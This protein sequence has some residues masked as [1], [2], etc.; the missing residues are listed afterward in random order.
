MASECIKQNFYF[1]PNNIIPS[2]DTPTLLNI[3][4]K[5]CCFELKVFGNTL[6]SDFLQNDKNGFLFWF[7]KDLIS[8]IDLSLEKLVNDNWLTVTGLSNNSYGTFYPWLFFVNDS[9]EGFIGYQIEWRNVLINFDEGAYRVKCSVTTVLGSSFSTTSLEYC[10]EKY[11]AFR[12]EGTVRIEYNISGVSGDK[13]NDKIKKDFG[14][15]FWY[16]SI[17][18]KGYFGFPEDTYEQDYVLYNNGQRAYVTD[19]QEPE[20]ILHLKHMPAYVH[21]IMSVDVLRADQILISDY[22]ARNAQRWVQKAVQ[23]PNEYKPV[24]KH[25]K[26]KQAPVTIRLRQEYNNLKKTRQ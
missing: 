2:Q 21:D 5:E 13:N 6:T 17:R 18:L 4:D 24:W 10:L 16:N 3:K 8:T 22:N 12:A 14:N 20:F 15:L 7:K 23:K 26:N 25:M 1:V 11:S 19:E 9:D